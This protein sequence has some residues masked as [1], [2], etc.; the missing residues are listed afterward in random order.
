[1]E[2]RLP[3]VCL[4]WNP[5]SL[6]PDDLSNRFDNLADF[7]DGL[8]LLWFFSRN[9]PDFDHGSRALRFLSHAMYKLAVVADVDTPPPMP[10]KLEPYIDALKPPVVLAFDGRSNWDAKCAWPIL[11]DVATECI[12]AKLL[13]EIERDTSMLSHV[14]SIDLCA[15][16]VANLDWTVTEIHQGISSAEIIGRHIDPLQALGADSS[17]SS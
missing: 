10:L 2:W 13:R 9:L 8:L 1:M 4:R 12:V 16:M 6:L 14:L 3:L 5:V 7:L 15:A 17:E 11:D